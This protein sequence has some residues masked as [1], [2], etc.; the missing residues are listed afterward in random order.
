MCLNAGTVLWY[1]HEYSLAVLNE[2][3]G[4]ALDSYDDNPIKRKFRTSWPWEQ[5]RQMA[6]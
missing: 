4:A 3:W 5:D 1:R 6:V 2:W